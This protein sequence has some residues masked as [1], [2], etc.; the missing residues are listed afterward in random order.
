MSKI[1]QN[2]FGLTQ[3]SIK[4][5]HTI[6]SKYPDITRVNIFGSR[7]KGNYKTGS[8]IDLAIINEGLSPKTISRVLGEC[9]ESSLPVK[10][11]LVDFNALTNPEFIDHINRI[12]VPFYSANG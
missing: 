3:R 9:N 5:L 12:G 6:F 4:E 10:V 7:A 1:S 11:D 8:D 2:T